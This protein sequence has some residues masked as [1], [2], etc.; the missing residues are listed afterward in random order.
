MESLHSNISTDDYED[1][2][3]KRSAREKAALAMSLVHLIM[4]PVA[5]IIFCLVF[6]VAEIS[7][8]DKGFELIDPSHPVFYFFLAQIFLTFFGYHAAWLACSMYTQ[9][10]A[11]ALPLTLATPLAMIFIQ[12][13]DVCNTSFIPLA[14][15]PQSGEDLYYLIGTCALLLLGQFL[16]T[17]YYVWANKGYIMGK[18]SHL[19]WLPSYTGK[20]IRHALNNSNNLCKGQGYMNQILSYKS[21]A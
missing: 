4:T 10:V 3:T 6:N 8:F 16:S 11:F 21:W 18:A 19:F 13:K 5:S 2:L 9:R 20:A 14:C 17:G 12:V 1:P 15:G 7:D